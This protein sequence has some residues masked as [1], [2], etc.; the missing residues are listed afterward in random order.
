MT[1]CSDELTHLAI[2][3][4][5]E[6]F[7]SWKHLSAKVIMPNSLINGCLITEIIVCTGKVILFASDSATAVKGPEGYCRYPDNRKCNFEFSIVF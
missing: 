5:T 1:D 3:S 7:K 4:A 2:D 6:A